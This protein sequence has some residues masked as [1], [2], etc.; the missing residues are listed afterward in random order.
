LGRLPCRLPVLERPETHDGL[1]DV[2]RFLQQNLTSESQKVVRLAE[3][4]NA[5][6]LL[7]LEQ[8]VR[9]AVRRRSVALEQEHAMARAVQTR[10]RQTAR[11]SSA[12]R[13]DVHQ[14]GALGHALDIMRSRR[15][16]DKPSLASW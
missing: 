7:A 10:A 12:Q 13:D 9:V 2:R 4:R 3:V 8:P 14:W 1:K 11:K 5:R 16:A 15:R 6:A